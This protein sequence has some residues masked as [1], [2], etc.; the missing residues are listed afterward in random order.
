[1]DE[2][3]GII[4]ILWLA[5]SSVTTISFWIGGSYDSS[6]VKLCDKNGYW[7]V[8]QTRIICHVEKKNG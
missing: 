4:L 5:V 8:D 6:V 1:M 3:L 2:A 7:Q